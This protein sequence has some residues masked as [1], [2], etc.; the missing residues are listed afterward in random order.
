MVQIILIAIIQIISDT[1][2][3]MQIKYY[4]LYLYFYSF[5]FLSMRY[6][7]KFIY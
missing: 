4:Y 2:K 3:G 7:K 1:N 5:S 6:D